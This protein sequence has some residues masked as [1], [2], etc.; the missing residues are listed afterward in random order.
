VLVEPT[1]AQV[2]EAG[3][4]TPLRTLLTPPAGFGA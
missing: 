3:H 2:V 4:D 1:A